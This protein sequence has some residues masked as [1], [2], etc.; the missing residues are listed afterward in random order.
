MPPLSSGPSISP[1]RALNQSLSSTDVKHLP[2]KI[3]YL[4]SALQNCNQVLSAPENHSTTKDSEHAVAIH[5]LRTRISS[6]LQDASPEGRW[7]GVVLAKAVV[8]VGGW[9]TLR[10]CGP[11]VKNILSIL[12][13]SDPAATKILCIAAL[14]RIFLLTLDYQ[15]LVR[16]INTPN[17][18]S[19]INFGLN[20]ITGKRTPESGGAKPN[21]SSP[22]LQP[23]LESFCVL[24]PNHPTLFR[25]FATQIHSILCHLVASTPPSPRVLI[26]GIEKNNALTCRVSEEVSEAARELFTL[27]HHCA[28]KQTASSEWSVALNA[29]VADAHTTADQVFRA[30][31]EDW[32]ST[33]SQLGTSLDPKT[34]RD[35][36]GDNR[37][38]SMGLPEWTGSFVSSRTYSSIPLPVGALL[39]LQSRILT[40]TVPDAGETRERINPAI[41]RDE[42]EALWI[43]LPQLHVAALELLSRMMQ[44]LGSS[45]LPVVQGSLEQVWWIF[46]AES[47]DRSIRCH[48]YEVLANLLHLGGSG[49]GKASI[50]QLSGVI[51]SCCNDLLPTRFAA[52]SGTLQ[53]NTP[54]GKS[55]QSNLASSSTNVDAFLPTK[56]SK[57]DLVSSTASSETDLHSRAWRLLPLFISNISTT[58]L[59]ASLRDQ[60]DRTAILTQHKNAMLASVLHQPPLKRNAK[61]TSSILPFLART[62]GGDLEIEG[63]LRPRMP[64]VRHKTL[65]ETRTDVGE[66]SEYNGQE[67][68]LYYP[69]KSSMDVDNVSRFERFRNRQDTEADPMVGDN[70]RLHADEDDLLPKQLPSSIE[71]SSVTMQAP[72]QSNIP[73][74]KRPRLES[75]PLSGTEATIQ[76]APQDSL[77]AT[78][79]TMLLSSDTKSQLGRTSSP[80]DSNYQNVLMRP[81]F[82]NAPEAVSRPSAL[83]PATAPVPAPAPTYPVP[84]SSTI[85][86]FGA[87]QSKAGNS[88]SDDDDEIPE[89]VFRSDSEDEDQEGEDDGD[90]KGADG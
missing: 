77:H 17:L 50:S 3:P 76:V 7:A 59:T 68:G 14:T 53:D 58:H 37:K 9:E 4:L 30:V 83:S 31:I 62:F 21:V 54:G 10:T 70:K 24:L 85:G 74:P 66:D 44:R 72:V 13:K 1:L 20:L 69:E 6:L 51:R 43:G 52:S 47:W 33:S 12:R 35:T 64:L 15:T 80:P 78:T 71:S 2:N 88:D 27:L 18:P 32:E 36:I 25:P 57:E 22:L 87:S 86:S 8:D 48:I 75:P 40:L 46:E 49:L 73:S 55:T 60:I 41:S 84:E 65:T 81:G 38:G 28:P 26:G 16:Q 5:K 34:L 56:A 11:W 90:S 23:V 63:L 82:E 89:L 79:N 61:P 45:F 39:D 29:V 19:Y 67:D 42:R